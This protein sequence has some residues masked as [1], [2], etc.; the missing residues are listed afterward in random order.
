MHMENELHALWLQLRDRLRDKHPMAREHGTLSLRLPGLNAMWFGHIDQTLPTRV[1][2]KEPG[3]AAALHARIYVRRGD[4]GAIAQG[5]GVFGW[6]LPDMGGAMPEVFDEQARHLGRMGPEVR[7]GRGLDE[8]L[9]AGGNVLLVDGVP[10]SLGTTGSRM[11]LNAELFEKC[12]KAYVLAVATG[13]PVKPLPW[14]VRTIA[15]RRLMKDERQAA[16]RMEDGL[17]PQESKGY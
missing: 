1:N 5:V 6:R 15:N 12:A 13:C 11:A 4:V 9:S 8:A 17:L 16:Q 10:V 3:A 2:L 14:L 7:Q